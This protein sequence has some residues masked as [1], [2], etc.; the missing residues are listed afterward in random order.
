MQ[1]NDSAL[2]ESIIWSD[3][4]AVSGAKYSFTA[5]KITYNTM[6]IVG[7][8]EAVFGDNF[9]TDYKN[10]SYALSFNI[11]PNH[12]DTAGILFKA[13]D[14][15]LLFETSDSISVV[16][17][18]GA[19]FSGYSV[20]VI[21]PLANFV[22]YNN[23][24]QLT[25][26]TF[27][28]EQID[29]MSYLCGGV[30]RDNRIFAN[31]TSNLTVLATGL[32]AVIDG[33]DTKIFA[34]NLKTLNIGNAGGTIGN[35][36]NTA[37]T[38]D[39][40]NQ[41]GGVMKNISLNAR[42]VIQVASHGI[43]DQLYVGGSGGQ[44]QVIVNVTGTLNNSVIDGTHAKA[45]SVICASEGAA[46]FEGYCANVTLNLA[47]SSSLLCRSLGCQNLTFRTAKDIDDM[48]I[49]LTECPCDKAVRS[50]C[51]E[52]DNQWN[53][54]C[55][56]SL[57]G[58]ASVFKDN[59]CHGECCGSIIDDLKVKNCHYP[60]G[61]K[62]KSTTGGI[63]GAVCGTILGVIMIAAAVYYFKKKKKAQ[64]EA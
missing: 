48:D 14:K 61:G 53:I 42:D 35:F 21:N 52:G 24:G 37:N 55:D 56:A 39:V 30:C 62:K 32:H 40:S 46:N 5:N 19:L 59:T 18:P 20:R 4:L 23:A 13:S 58:V 8:G 51:I 31:N 38:V 47:T 6:Q 2:S 10:K 25:N 57:N 63:V 9:F 11:G 50:S 3:S 28:V 22:V 41:F 29:A 49:T 45:L 17:D 54:Y 12:Q 60:G 34:P 64:Q 33:M 43:I 27:N 15:T 44:S 1:G 16:I 7:N 36:T 26:T